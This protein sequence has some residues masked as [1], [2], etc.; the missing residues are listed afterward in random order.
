M[1]RTR[2]L[3]GNTVIWTTNQLDNR[4]LGYNLT[5]LATANWA[6]HSGQLGDNIGRV[7]EDVNVGIN[8]HIL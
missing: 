5:W 4:R 3:F 8:V 7:L 1:Y 2:M 6:T